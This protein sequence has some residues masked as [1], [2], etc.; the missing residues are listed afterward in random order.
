MHL[1]SELYW[2][3]GQECGTV[4]RILHDNNVVWGAYRDATGTHM[5]A[6]A[7]NFVL[8]S[9]ST[10]VVASSTV[11]AASPATTASAAATAT[12]PSSSSSSSLFSPSL[13][14]PLDF[15]MAYARDNCT[16]PSSHSST[17]AT[18]PDSDSNDLFTQMSDQEFCELGFNL[19]MCQANQASTSTGNTSLSDVTQLNTTHFDSTQL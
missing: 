9:P 8:L 4:G 18:N 14:A 13:L 6:H 2:Q 5:N 15:D 11:I 16:F 12:V 3:F 10:A 17:V 7:N 19:A 1:L